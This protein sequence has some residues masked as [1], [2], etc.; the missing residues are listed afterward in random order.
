MSDNLFSVASGYAV[1]GPLIGSYGHFGMG[2][3]DSY[4]EAYKRLVA[5]Y[6]QSLYGHISNIAMGGIG[7]VLIGKLPICSMDDKKDHNVRA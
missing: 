5:Y 7:D 3:L 4:R 2:I 6:R 1:C